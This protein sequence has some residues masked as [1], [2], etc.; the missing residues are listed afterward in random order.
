MGI[1]TPELREDLEQIRE[2]MAK[3]DREKMKLKNIAILITRGILVG[4]LIG[5]F[6]ALI[7][8]HDVASGVIGGSVAGSVLLAWVGL[9]GNIAELRNKRN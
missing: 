4:G 6:S 1:Y 3:F 7:S 8:W 2:A 9:G 5:G